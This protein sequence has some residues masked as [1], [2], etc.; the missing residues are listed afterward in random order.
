[1]KCVN[2]IF[3]W[4]HFSSSVA[5][6][7]NQGPNLAPP[8]V[9][10]TDPATLIHSGWQS[11]S[12]AETV[13]PREPARP[14]T[15]NAA[16]HALLP[17]VGLLSPALRCLHQLSCHA[18]RCFCLSPA[19]HCFSGGCTLSVPCMS[20]ARGGA[21]WSRGS[22]QPLEVLLVRTPRRVRIAAPSASATRVFKKSR[23]TVGGQ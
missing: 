10:N 2:Q 5:G 19:L 8:V 20:P 21:S 22:P 1:M 14:F 17:V 7:V 6:V 23:A 9:V 12:T 18:P 3:G 11:C 15:E 16:A 4:G 13:R